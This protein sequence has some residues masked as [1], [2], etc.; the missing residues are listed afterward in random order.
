MQNKI[1]TS[2]IESLKQVC[3]DQISLFGKDTFLSID[4]FLRSNTFHCSIN[5]EIINWWIVEQKFDY[6]EKAGL[7]LN[8]LMKQE[9]EMNLIR[10]SST[11]VIN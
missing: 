9:K 10:S 5:A 2:V 4:T 8:T 6:I 7:V 3:F 1:D 11:P